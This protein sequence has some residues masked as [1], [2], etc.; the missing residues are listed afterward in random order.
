MPYTRNPV[1]GADAALWAATAV[2]APET[3]RLDADQHCDIAIVGAGFTGLN[4]AIELAQRG[5][6][7]CVLE[8]GPLGTG[9]SGRS[10]GQ[11]NQGLNLSPSQLLSRFGSDAGQR[12]VATVLGAPARVFDNVSRLGLDCDAV[13][14]G[15]IQAAVTQQRFA[16]QKLAAEEYIA[17]G[18]EFSVLERDALAQASGA[19]G[20]VGG[21]LCHAA[22]SIHP[23]SY[24]RELARVAIDLGTS[25]FTNSLISD[26]QAH[27]TGWKLVGERATV[28]ADKVLLCTNAYTDALWPGL[29]E[30][31]V[32]V[33]SVLA[34]TEPLSDNLRATILPGEVTFVDKRRLILYCRYDRDGRLCIG[35]H[36]PLRDNFTAADFDRVKRRALEV[37]PQLAGTRW[38]YHWGGR[39][40][41][42]K[43]SLPFLCQPAPGLIAA[44]GYNGRGVAMGSKLGEVAAGFAIDNDAEQCA[45]P[46]TEPRAFFGHRWHPPGIKLA[47]AW[48]GLQDYLES[49][50][51]R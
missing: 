16:A 21:T 9:A 29:A 11:V 33:R 25:I 15:W 5:V 13:Q 50:R 48:H 46:V 51:E 34:A 7:V 43:T 47:L 24:T 45:F 30:R 17:H 39:V 4:A 42:T 40:G 32:P 23:L 41:M 10:G 20:F 44:M 1:A 35:D 8:A 31:I 3:R 12:M 2:P 37:F 38:E 19:D 49:R 27:N 14:A 28:M 6:Q 36:G 22:G 26:L 18:A